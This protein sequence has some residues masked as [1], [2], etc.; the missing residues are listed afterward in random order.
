MLASALVG[1]RSTGSRAW[2]CCRASAVEARGQTDAAGGA[3]KDGKPTSAAV[4]NAHAIAHFLE[5][6]PDGALAADQQDANQELVD[7][8]TSG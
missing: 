3:G 7:G 4:G 2:T 6:A 1:V 5:T 8:R